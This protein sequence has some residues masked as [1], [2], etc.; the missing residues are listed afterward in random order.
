M[1]AIDRTTEF[2]QQIDDY[3]S[4]QFA[5][6]LPPQKGPQYAHE[7]AQAQDARKPK[8]KLTKTENQIEF[9]KFLK[10]LQS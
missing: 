1:S 7:R 10:D 9:E 2:T 5:T 6:V 8:V 4:T 3:L